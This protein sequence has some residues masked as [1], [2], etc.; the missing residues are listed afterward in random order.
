MVRLRNHRQDELRRVRRVMP[1]GL[2][3]NLHCGARVRVLAGVQV[4]IPER[5]ITAGDFLPDRVAF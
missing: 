2:P 5:E 3:G 1:D 4:P